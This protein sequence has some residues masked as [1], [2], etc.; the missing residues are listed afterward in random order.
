MPSEPEMRMPY[1]P[2]WEDP[3]WTPHATPDP[4][5]QAGADAPLADDPRPRVSTLAQFMDIVK[6]FARPRPAQAGIR[7]RPAA[8]AADASPP[9]RPAA[10]TAYAGQTRRWVVAGG[11][12]LL[13]I[14]TIPLPHDANAA[15]AASAAKPPRFAGAA[16]ERD[17][18][19]DRT[20]AP[21]EEG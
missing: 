3:D 15:Q 8:P 21:R 4:G 16:A 6:R 17:E 7:R 9:G 2:G 13:A 20:A 10:E 12:G 18:P 14:T 19:E 5:A 1:G 11:A